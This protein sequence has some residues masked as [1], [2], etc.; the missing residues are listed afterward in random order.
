MVDVR[1]ELTT[2]DPH[3]LPSL[4]CVTV[5]VRRAKGNRLTNHLPNLSLIAVVCVVVCGD[6][7]VAVSCVAR[8][9]SP[10]LHSP[11]PKMRFP[12]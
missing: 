9:I 4:P 10:V 1:F 3:V 2:N 6:E 5:L 8:D 12:R 11:P 7:L